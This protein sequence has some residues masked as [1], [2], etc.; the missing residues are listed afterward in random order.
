M[1]PSLPNPFARGFHNL[2]YER[3]LQISYDDAYPPC[4]RS[5]HPAQKQL[6]DEAICLQPCLFDD[7]C[8]F[9][10]DSERMPE[11]V[12]MPS[13]ASGQ[14]I[15][16]VYQ[17]IGHQ[18][19]RPQHLG[20]VANEETARYLLEQWSFATGHYSRSWEIS[21]AHLPAD[22]LEYLRQRVLYGSPA[23]FF[24]CFILPHSHAVGCKLYTPPWKME[25]DSGGSGTAEVQARMSEDH[26]PSTLLQLLLLAGEAD[27]RF[28]IFD[29]DAAPLAELPLFTDN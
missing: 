1:L 14:V 19:G 26:V 4:Y 12:Q 21:C 2:S 16:V 25:I 8:A 9:I 7:D 20:D 5:L 18:L 27:A 11:S 22:E 24:E 6:P 13:P 23:G 15:S 3:V 28:L 10:T 29:P 17:I